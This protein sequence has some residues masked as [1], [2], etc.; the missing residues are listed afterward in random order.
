MLIGDCLKLFYVHEHGGIRQTQDTYFYPV[1]RASEVF[2]KFSMKLVSI[3]GGA[4]P[5]VKPCPI[6]LDQLLMLAMM[7]TADLT[8]GRETLLTLQER[9]IP[10]PI[11][12]E[13]MLPLC[14]FCVCSF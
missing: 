4:P 11:L 1:R 2:Y 10:P 8:C 14:V 13:Y 3:K 5:P 9:L 7:Y 12:Y 6:A